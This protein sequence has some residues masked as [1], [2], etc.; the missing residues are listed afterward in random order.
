MRTSRRVREG[1]ARYAEIQEE[2]RMRIG[3]VKGAGATTYSSRTPFLLR[4]RRHETPL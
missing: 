2:M 4:C 1:A 3:S